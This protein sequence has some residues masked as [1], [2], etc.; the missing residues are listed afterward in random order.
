M[1]APRRIVRFR[2]LLQVDQDK[3][4][5][6]P[7]RLILPQGVQAY[8]GYVPATVFFDNN[9]DRLPRC[10]HEGVRF[11]LRLLGVERN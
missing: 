6:G 4:S 7:L 9:P 8:S 10:Y 11:D 3:V 2:R 1:C 5:L